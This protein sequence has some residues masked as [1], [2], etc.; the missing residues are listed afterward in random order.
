MREREA[1]GERQGD[2]DAVRQ[3][4][5]RAERQGGS[6]AERVCTNAIKHEWLGS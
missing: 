6:R 4:G 1:R 5:R 2:S 3:R